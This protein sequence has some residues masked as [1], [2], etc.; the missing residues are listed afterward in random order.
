MTVLNKSTKSDPARSQPQVRIEAISKTFSRRGE[1]N[2]VLDDVSL[3]IDEGEFLV[4]LGPSGCG[5]TT[6]LRSLVGLERPDAGT[7]DLRGERVVDADRGMYLPPNRRDVSMVF[8]NYA[9]WPHMTVAKN[10]AY[11]LKARRMR[12]AL[13][14]GRVDSVLK[15]VQCEHLAKRY[16]PELSGGQQQRV[17]LA[18]ALVSRPSLLLLDEPLSNLDVLLRVELRAQLRLLHTQLRFTGVYVTHDQ[19]EALALGSRVAVMRAGR[20]DQIGEPS[21]VYRQPATEYVADFLGARNKLS[22]SI[23]GARATIDGQPVGGIAVSAEPDEYTLRVR[24]ADVRVRPS[25][26][27]GLDGRTA[28]LSEGTLVEILPG[29]QHD[30]YVVELRG[31]RFFASIPHGSCEARPGDS[32]DIGLDLDR[33]LCYRNDVLTPA[34]SHTPAGTR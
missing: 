21:T 6:L 31:S 5:K 12:D 1:T 10:V 24:A 26:S 20:I 17:S 13:K 23:D 3:D 16:P 2:R 11:P 34:F 22:M 14:E 19:D 7:I 28:W 8:Q 32:V 9:L 33:T 30:E 25:G 27:P 4:L 15:V 29:A 18:R